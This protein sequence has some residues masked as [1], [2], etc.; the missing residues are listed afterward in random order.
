MM[1]ADLIDLPQIQMIGSPGAVAMGRNAPGQVAISGVV[2][3]R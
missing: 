1:M 3:K 2:G